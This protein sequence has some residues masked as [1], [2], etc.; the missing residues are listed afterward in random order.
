MTY[1]LSL[2]G[3]AAAAAL[4]VFG[5]TADTNA[6]ATPEHPIA[7]AFLVEE[8]R[9]GPAMKGVV[10]ANQDVAGQFQ[11]TFTKRGANSANVTQ[12][13]RFDLNAGE[14]A[15]LGQAT[16]GRGTVDAKLVLTIGGQDLVCA[17]PGLTDL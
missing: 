10:T 7:C 11:M 1:A 17:T 12:S 14:T 4:T 13:G 9:F 6:Q 16:L 8:G 15:T 3:L 5:F 2:T